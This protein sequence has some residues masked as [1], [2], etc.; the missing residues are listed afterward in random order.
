M[1]TI[2]NTCLILS[3]NITVNTK[4]EIFGRTCWKLYEGADKAKN[5]DDIFHQPH[6]VIFN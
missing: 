1:E 5:N 6:E 2:H 3:A 4:E